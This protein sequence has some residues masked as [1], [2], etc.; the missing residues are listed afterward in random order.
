LQN[1][2]AP[3]IVDDPPFFD[4]IQGSKAAEAGKVIVQAAISYA[5][6]LNGAVDITH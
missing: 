4:L 2:T 1:D 5:R 6:G 3:V